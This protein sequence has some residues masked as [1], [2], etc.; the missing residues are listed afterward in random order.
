MALAG[1]GRGAEAVTELGYYQS[2]FEGLGSWLFGIEYES[3]RDT[4]LGGPSGKE[5]SVFGPWLLWEPWGGC[6]LGTREVSD[7]RPCVRAKVVPQM[8]PF[9]GNGQSSQ[10]RWCN[11]TPAG[12]KLESASRVA[13]LCRSP[14]LHSWFPQ[15]PSTWLSPQLLLPRAPAACVAADRLLRVSECTRYIPASGGMQRRRSSGTKLWTRR[16]AFA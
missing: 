12:G 15:F 7:Y 4:G 16:A 14:L 6:C 11:F 5:S 3:F 10:N 1:R 13:G 9:R 8:I 2:V